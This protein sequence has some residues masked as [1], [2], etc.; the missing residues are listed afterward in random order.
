M[1]RFARSH[2][3]T[4]QVARRGKEKRGEVANQEE[5]LLGTGVHSIAIK[6]V[7]SHNLSIRSALGSKPKCMA[8]LAV[9]AAG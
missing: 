4:C 5:K 1:L 3:M 9:V 8:G 6:I 2:V 7:L